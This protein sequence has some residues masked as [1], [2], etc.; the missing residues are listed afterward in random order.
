VVVPFQ[1]LRDRAED[2]MVSVLGPADDEDDRGVGR[3][4]QAQLVGC[5][6]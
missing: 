2:V 1:G 6:D 3:A 5:R 4:P